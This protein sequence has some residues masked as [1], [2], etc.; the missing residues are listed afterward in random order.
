MTAVLEIK[1]TGGLAGNFSLDATV[2]RDGEEG[3][4][5]FYGSTYGGPVVMVTSMG[6]TFVD[7]PQRFG[8]RLSEEWVRRFFEER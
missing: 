6:Q 8:D 4:V 7:D 1:R 3:R 2:E 5:T